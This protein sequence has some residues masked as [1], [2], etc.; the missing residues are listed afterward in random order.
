MASTTW[1]NCRRQAL[2]WLGDSLVKGWTVEMEAICSKHGGFNMVNGNRNG[3]MINI[4]NIVNIV[5]I[6]EI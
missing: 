5:N 2:K 1:T 4:M 6:L 3:N